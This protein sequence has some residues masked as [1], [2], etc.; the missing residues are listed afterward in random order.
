MVE[1]REITGQEGEQDQQEPGDDQ[2]EAE[3]RERLIV[4]LQRVTSRV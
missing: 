4:G 3:G 1:T 2:Y